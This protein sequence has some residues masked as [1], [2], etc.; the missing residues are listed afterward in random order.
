[1]KSPRFAVTIEVTVINPKLAIKVARERAAADGHKR[2]EIRDTRDAVHW[3][4]DPGSLFEQGI[5]I[6]GSAIEGQS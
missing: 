5:E 6:D 1:M 3:L 4:L 2:G